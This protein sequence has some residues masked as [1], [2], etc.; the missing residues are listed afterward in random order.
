MTHNLL[1]LDPHCCSTQHAQ[2]P[3]RE[4]LRSN[5]LASANGCFERIVGNPEIGNGERRYRNVRCGGTQN[6]AHDVTAFR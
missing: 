4:R 2:R 6:H 3:P 1:L 5:A